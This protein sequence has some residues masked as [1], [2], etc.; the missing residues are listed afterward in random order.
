MLERCFQL[1]IANMMLWKDVIAFYVIIE[2]V[3]VKNRIWPDGQAYLEETVFAI[4]VQ[5]KH[6]LKDTLVTVLIN[7][8]LMIIWLF[9]FLIII[10]SLEHFINLNK[11][12][13]R[14]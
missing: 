9:S 12:P 11:V 5:I 7:P 2:L 6:L 14:L 10:Y 3:H 8:L 4:L 1:V 13:L